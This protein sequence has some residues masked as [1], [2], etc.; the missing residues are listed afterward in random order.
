[1]AGGVEL[2]YR[3]R[4]Y[5]CSNC[6]QE[7]AGHRVIRKGPPEF[8]LQPHPLYPM[9]K[10]DFD[11]WLDIFRTYFPDDPLLAKAYKEWRPGAK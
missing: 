2:S 8:F 3:Q 9:T 4:T 1:M 5:T 11:Y 7:T 10:E 6:H